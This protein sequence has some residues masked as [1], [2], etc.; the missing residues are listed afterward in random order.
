MKLVVCLS[1]GVSVADWQR[2][3]ILGRETVAYRNRPGLVMLLAS[4]LTH[5][6]EGV[7][8]SVEPLRILARPRWCPMP[9]YSLIGPVIHWRALRVCDEI[10]THNGPGVWT[11]AI[12]RMLFGGR[13]VARF[14]FIWSWDMVRRGVPTWKVLPV[15][16][17]EWLACRLA[18]RIEVSVQ[19]QAAYLRAVH[20]VR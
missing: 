8:R 19:T 16:V 2:Q 13:L 11:A 12:A 10:R 14:G 17:G 18:D 1:Y 4:D 7:A 5:S 20:G 15:L 3:G 6:A 9:L